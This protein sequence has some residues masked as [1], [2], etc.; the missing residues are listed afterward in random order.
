MTAPRRPAR[1]KALGYGACVPIPLSPPGLE[2]ALA[3]K[4]VHQRQ[5]GEGLCE[6]G[7]KLKV[8]HLRTG[9]FP[10]VNRVLRCPAV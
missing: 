3:D 8:R 7:L 9:S 5:N 6:K 1:L 10:P 2:L 4:D